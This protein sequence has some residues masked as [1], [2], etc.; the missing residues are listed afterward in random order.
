M[1]L[2]WKVMVPLGLINL[3]VAAVLV[4]YRE[5]IAK[6]VG[7][8]SI[9]VTI[10]LSWAITLAAWIIAGLLAPLST[11]NTPRLSVSPFDAEQEMSR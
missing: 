2:A 5:P 9:W 4:E 6:G 3:V 1:A 7:I 8:D 11:D 10:V